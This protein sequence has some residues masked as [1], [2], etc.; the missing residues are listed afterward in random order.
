MS[1][2]NLSIIE[3]D[4]LIRKMPKD[5]LQQEL[6]QPSGNFPLYM[7][8]ARLKE[9]EDM[10]KEA[11]ARQMAEQSSQEAPTVAARLAMQA[12]PQGAMSSIGAMP[13]PQPRPDP[14][15]QMA[16]QLAGPQQQMPTVRAQRG[17]K[18]AY[19][20]DTAPIDADMIAAAV[21]ERQ[22]KGD[23]RLYNLGRK[24]GFEQA[25]RKGATP[26]AQIAAMLG[27]PSGVARAQERAFGGK[28]TLPPMQV[29]SSP[30]AMSRKGF[31]SPTRGVAP[32][33]EQPAGL[34]LIKMLAQL[35]DDGGK[36][37][38]PTVFAQSGM[39]DRTKAALG[40]M[41]PD[42]ASLVAQFIQDKAAQESEVDVEEQSSEA[43]F[44]PLD[45]V[46]RGKLARMQ[47]LGRTDVMAPNDLPPTQASEDVSRLMIPAGGQYP[48]KVTGDMPQG[49]R[50]GA[51]A[52]QNVKST[53]DSVGDFLSDAATQGLA[54][55]RNNSPSLP[56]VTN[57]PN[58]ML[59]N[60]DFSPTNFNP[61]FDAVRRGASAVGQKVADSPLLRPMSQKARDSAAAGYAAVLDPI[62][63]ALINDPEMAPEELL[64]SPTE[65]GSSAFAQA[66]ERSRNRPP[67]TMKKAGERGTQEF[68]AMFSGKSQPEVQ[69]SLRRKIELAKT[70]GENLDET[71]AQVLGQQASPAADA[72]I[73]SFVSGGD[74]LFGE[75]VSTEKLSDGITAGDLSLGS[76][77]QVA[78]TVT[79]NTDP[80]AAPMMVRTAGPRSATVETA[81]VEI[82]PSS[83]VG[84]G[85]AVQSTS[86][87]TVG[88][89]AEKLAAAAPNTDKAVEIDVPDSKTILADVAKMFPKS[90]ERRT[91]RGKIVSDFETIADKIDAF[92]PVPKGLKDI[93]GMYE[94]RLEALETSGL[95]FMTAAAAVLKGNQQPLVAMT[96]AM[97]GYTAGDEK[98]KK[99]GLKIMGDIVKL[100]T[101]IATLEQAQLKVEV[102]A[103]QKVLEARKNQIEGNAADERAQIATAMDLMKNAQALSL[104]KAKLEDSARNRANTLAASTF[105]VREERERFDTLVGEY[106]KQ[107]GMT[108]VQAIEK[109]YKAMKPSSSRNFGMTATGME[110][111]ERSAVGKLKD[112][113]R[114]LVDEHNNANPDQKISPLSSKDAGKRNQIL[115]NKLQKGDIPGLTSLELEILRRKYPPSAGASA[116]TG[117]SDR[118]DISRFD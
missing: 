92:D 48:F 76:E 3:K 82:V 112:L 56:P 88:N 103:R 27:L 21:R 107:E 75:N 20:G 8:A 64:D 17:L 53:A 79:A 78:S 10:E 89:F 9:V 68:L 85:K 19:A 26:A 40:N 93:R 28:S 43:A 102:E 83:D 46:L 7:V 100:D 47:E 117:A 73:A 30:L 90:A 18:G 42:A 70:G 118:G 74:R 44:G 86:V 87:Q 80:K 13:A 25:G 97:I 23:P 101:N 91:A 110:A 24:A 113:Q 72:G 33:A 39:I 111:A 31:T 96:N 58:R 115:I 77:Q 4:D 45:P 94:K 2:A 84:S 15:G 22:R 69:E 62:A 52:L 6:R 54:S 49:L 95:P 63:A 98:A 114:R 32:K 1:L 109:A 36:E 41:S 34:D 50:G 81:A 99:Q 104:A 108:K 11:T 59:A 116:P 55:I 57:E 37:E 60:Q 5:S 61:A 67:T 35:S 71:A 38:L 105:K 66:L 29:E 65:A 16:Q 51:E 14:Q 106:M 12:M